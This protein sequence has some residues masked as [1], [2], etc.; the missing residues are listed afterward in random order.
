[1]VQKPT[2]SAPPEEESLDVRLDEEELA[3]MGQ[4][5]SAPSSEPQEAFEPTVKIDLSMM[6]EDLD[7]VEEEEELPPPPPAKPRRSLRPVAFVGGVIVLLAVAAVVLWRLGILPLPGAG[8]EAPTANLIIDQDRL[9]GRWEKNAQV[10]RI[11][12]VKG[13]VVNRSKRPR[14]FI[15]VEA[16][17]MD[18][19]GKPVRKTWAYCGNLIPLR[20]LR[21]KGK[22]AI[23]KYMKKREGE[24]GSNKRVLPGAS[25]PFMAVFFDVPQGVESYGA[26]VVGAVIP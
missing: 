14:A 13:M 1:M 22:G 18:R 19:S 25:I 23:E 21:T 16:I 9:D 5:E 3:Q 12:V 26:K 4:E 10:S 7:Y 11:F 24:R 8:T 20:D 15:K 6:Q 17:L 2:S